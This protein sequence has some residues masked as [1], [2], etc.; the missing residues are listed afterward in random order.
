MLLSVETHILHEEKSWDDG[1]RDGERGDDG[2]PPVGMGT[3]GWYL[4]QIPLPSSSGTL[5]LPLETRMNLD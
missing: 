2:G 3:T 1:S 5:P 4:L